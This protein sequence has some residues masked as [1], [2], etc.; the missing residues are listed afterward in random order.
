MRRPSIA[1]RQPRAGENLS[2]PCSRPSQRNAS[3][4]ASAT[5]PNSQ[6]ASLMR[7]KNAK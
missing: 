2:L 3:P 7:L 5:L 4:P 6:A 1:P